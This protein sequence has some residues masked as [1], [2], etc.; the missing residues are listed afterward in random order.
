MFSL[1]S[2]C[3]LVCTFLLFSL[4]IC[5][6]KFCLHVASN[7]FCR[8]VLFPRVGSHYLLCSLCI[9]FI[10]CPSVSSYT[11]SPLLLFFLRF[12]PQCSN[13]HSRTTKLEGSVYCKIVFFCS[14]KVF[15]PLN[16]IVYNACYFQIAIKFVIN[17]NFLFMRQNFLSIILLQFSFQLDPVL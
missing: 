5:Y 9:C 2:F 16:I 17:G 13:F 11:S 3:L 14:F 6:E 15:C 7:F 12:L 1:R 8:P 4:E 10:N